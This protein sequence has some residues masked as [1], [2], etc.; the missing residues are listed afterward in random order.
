V[1]TKVAQC[2]GSTATKPPA[3][4]AGPPAGAAGPG[5]AAAAGI[6]AKPL[7]NNIILAI[8]ELA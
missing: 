6:F 4:L 8:L 5:L 1:A 3:N 7:N 2:M